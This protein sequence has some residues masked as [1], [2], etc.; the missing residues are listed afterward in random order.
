MSRTL[1]GNLTG[2]AARD[3]MADLRERIQHDAEQREKAKHLTHDQFMDVCW[4][5][6]DIMGMDEYLEWVDAQPEKGFN[7]RAAEMLV[8]LHSLAFDEPHPVEEATEIEVVIDGQLPYTRIFNAQLN[9]LNSGIRYPE[10]KA[11]ADAIAENYE[12]EFGCGNDS[13]LHDLAIGR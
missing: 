2:K 11:V 4:A 9:K 10:T 6:S 3:E 13:D 12:A 5:L 7:D 8:A 1:N